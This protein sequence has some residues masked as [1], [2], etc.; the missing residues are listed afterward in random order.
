MNLQE[1]A[2][3]KKCGQFLHPLWFDNKGIKCV[4]KE[5]EKKKVALG[6]D[7]EVKMWLEHY[8]STT[9]CLGEPT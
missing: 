8:R 9:I 7:V 2:S 4:E 5:D 1:S 3:C 6:L